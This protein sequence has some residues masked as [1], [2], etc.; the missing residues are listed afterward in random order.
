MPWDT[1]TPDPLLVEMIESG[2]REALSSL[3]RVRPYQPPRPPTIRV[4][5]TTPDRADRW[6]NRVGVEIAEPR[7]VIARGDD[8]WQAWQRLWV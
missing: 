3:G 7:L 6:R 2:A 1:G 4:A 5:L 8:F